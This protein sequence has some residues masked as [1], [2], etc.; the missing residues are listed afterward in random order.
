MLSTTAS[1]KC[2]ELTE[3]GG[4]EREGRGAATE[5][6]A[7]RTALC[8]ALMRVDGSLNATVLVD[9]NTSLADF[10]THSKKCWESVT[11]DS[12]KSDRRRIKS[13]THRFVGKK[14]Q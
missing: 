1:N 11:W 8:I 9:W 2:R 4:E 10:V 14:I 3:T 13:L 12:W 7:Q 5:I 6:K